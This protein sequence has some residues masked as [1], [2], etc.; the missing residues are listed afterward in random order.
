[1]LED[2]YI[3]K[4]ICP[5]HCEACLCWGGSEVVGGGAYL[6]GQDWYQP[7]ATVYLWPLSLKLR[8]LNRSAWNMYHLFYFTHTHTHTHTQGL[9]IDFYCD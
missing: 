2:L 6:A 7:D 3:C 4:S 9:Y 8:R 5:G 1:M